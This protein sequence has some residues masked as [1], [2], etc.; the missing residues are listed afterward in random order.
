M[1]AGRSKGYDKKTDAEKWRLAQAAALIRPDEQ[2]S[3]IRAPRVR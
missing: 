1:V 2:H 3:K